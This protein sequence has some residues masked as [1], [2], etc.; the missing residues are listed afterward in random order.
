MLLT[1]EIRSVVICD[2]VIAF[3]LFIE[4]RKPFIG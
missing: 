3:F 1:Q 2:V 4:K